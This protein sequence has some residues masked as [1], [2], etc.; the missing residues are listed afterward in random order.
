M[1]KK[2]NSPYFD[3]L[4]LMENLKNYASPKAKLTTMIKSGE[5]IRLRRGLFIAGDSTNY[6]IKTLANKIYGPSYVSFEYALAY[7]NLIPERVE[8]LTCA[9]FAKNKN[10]Y[11]YTPIRTFLYKSIPS[12]A[13]P[14]GIIREEE[15]G[16]PFLI[17]TKEKALCDTLSKISGIT[18]I[19]SLVTLLF[20]DLRL[21][22]DELFALNMKDMAFLTP[23][24]KKVTL[25]L[26]L[27]YLQSGAPN[28]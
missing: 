23:L 16:N 24:Y 3:H 2:V 5:V 14:Y 10:K 27:R 8:T 4:Y 19:K 28:A 20:D 12:S 25:N 9:T 18:S 1:R 11:F 26:F 13:Y 17:A 15:N 22:M 7:Y 6:S 21:D